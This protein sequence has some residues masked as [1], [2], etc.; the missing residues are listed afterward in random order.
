MPPPGNIA[1]TGVGLAVPGVT[2]PADLMRPPA[3]SAGPVD[4]AE[5]IGRRGLRYLDRASQLA[6][7]AAHDALREAA[8]PTAASENEGG[9]SVAV[10]ASSN[11][12]NLD[13]VCTVTA[14]IAEE[15]T[16]RISPMRLP[17]ASSNVV[18]SAVATRFSLRGP[19]LMLCNGPTS[20][21]DAVHWGMSLLSANRGSQSLV[22]GVE[23]SNTVVERLLGSSG[24]RLFDGAVALLLEDEETARAR[25]AEPVARLGPYRR[26]GSLAAC[27]HHLTGQD[28]EAPGAAGLW[29]S[30]PAH[31]T[32]T[33]TGTGADDGAD[34]AGGAPALPRYDLSADHGEA[35]GALGVLQCAAAV[36]W[37]P[38]HDASSALLTNGDGDDADAVAAML[39]SPVG[40]DR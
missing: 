27:V 16:D 7:C 24:R 1:V 18:A 39:I 15:G 32:G 19:S 36:G 2:A 31:G 14:D 25:G 26:E 17:V 37:F 8:L 4:P 23:T 40:G 21:L 28:R 35:S 30:G 34:A 6:L 33:G 13:T 11:L 5:R 22:V 20:G 38:S 9:A 12:G 3:P 29:L 10:V